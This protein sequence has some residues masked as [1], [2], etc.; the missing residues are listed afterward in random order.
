MQRIYLET[1]AKV[2]MN[3]KQKYILDA[4]GGDVLKLLNL[5]EIIK[6][7]GE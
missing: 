2:L 1:M 7:K 4:S 5:S 3:V 6:K